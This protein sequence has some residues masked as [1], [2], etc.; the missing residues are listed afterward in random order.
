M[1]HANSTL[2]VLVLASL[3]TGTASA[4]VREFRFVDIDAFD[5]DALDLRSYPGDPPLVRAPSTMAGV[6]AGPNPDDTLGRPIARLELDAEALLE[7]AIAPLERGRETDA[8]LLEFRLGNQPIRMAVVEIN[9]DTSFDAVH[10]TLVDPNSNDYG[11]LT[12]SRIG[13][14]VVGSF[15]VDLDELRLLPDAD[16]SQLV[17]PVVRRAG[18]F[19]REA[20]P[21]LDTRAGHLEAR[22][23][24]LAWAAS[25]QPW[26]SFGTHADGRLSRYG[27]EVSLGVLAWWDGV[28]IDNAGTISTN[29]ERLAYEIGRFFDSTRHLLMLNERIDVRVDGAELELLARGAAPTA[30]VAFIQL[31]DNIPVDQD[32]AVSINQ[33]GGVLSYAGAPIPLANVA[34]NDGTWITRELALRL[35]EDTVRFR[36]QP[37]WEIRLDEAELV[38]V[39]HG[40][41][42]ADPVWRIDFE[43]DCRLFYRVEIDP[44]AHT[45][46]EAL[47]LL[48][49]RPDG[50]E[51]FWDKFTERQTC[52]SGA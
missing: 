48:T 35:A 40:G 16:G 11:R 45:A 12:V 18:E 17:Y 14:D 32:L 44:I 15:F 21:D 47:E 3:A 29:P 38:Y 23:L 7:A 9:A 51:G 50:A 33:G 43:T 41:T 4:Q 10:Y 5:R 31:I 8:V 39:V 13:P 20:M 42:S 37:Q 34:R 2:L 26:S 46:G 22:H 28:D 30:S 6:G 19:R 1:R 49:E 36:W 24:Q 52:Q 25:N 27:G